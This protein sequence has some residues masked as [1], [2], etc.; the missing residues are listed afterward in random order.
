M[1][2][3]QNFALNSMNYQVIHILVKTLEDNR[4]CKDTTM[5][6]FL[7][8]TKIPKSNWTS[9]PTDLGSICALQVKVGPDR[10]VSDGLCLRIAII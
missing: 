3:D 1:K 9:L 6:K 10:N 4:M 2:N 5:R 7:Y 8:E